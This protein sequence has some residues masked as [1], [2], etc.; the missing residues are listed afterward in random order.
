VEFGP[1][2][3]FRPNWLPKNVYFS[4]DFMRGAYLIKGYYPRHPNYN[5]I[6]IGFWYAKTTK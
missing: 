2:V 4:C 1:G 6:R 3:R 5:D